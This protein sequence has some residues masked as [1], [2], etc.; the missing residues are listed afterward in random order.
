MVLG[1]FG[2][3]MTLHDITQVICGVMRVKKSL[4]VD[5]AAPALLLIN[6]SVYLGVFR[7][8]YEFQRGCFQTALCI[9]RSYFC[10]LGTCQD[11]SELHGARN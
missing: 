5:H 6:L 2:V 10:G 8:N 3:H 1:S 7:M 11:R 4:R 9:S